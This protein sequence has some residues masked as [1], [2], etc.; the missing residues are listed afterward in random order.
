[1]L[2]GRETIKWDQPKFLCPAT[3]CVEGV[4][5]C[6]ELGLQK[7]KRGEPHGSRWA[8][9]KDANSIKEQKIKNK[10]TGSTHWLQ[11]FNEAE[12][13]FYNKG[14]PELSPNMGREQRNKE[15]IR[16]RHYPHSTNCN[17]CVFTSGS[18]KDTRWGGWG[19]KLNWNATH[20]PGANRTQNKTSDRRAEKKNY[21]I[22]CGEWAKVCKFVCT[23]D[24]WS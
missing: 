14:W 23:N 7:K 19:E 4:G 10:K 17:C 8:K 18:N 21:S 15:R 12:S 2:P 20:K 9:Q 22:E 24:L 16:P 5:V 13:S 1:M 3:L 11:I 6:S